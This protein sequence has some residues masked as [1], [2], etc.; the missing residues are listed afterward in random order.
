M[1]AVKTASLQASMNILLDGFDYG[2][3]S[4][5]FGVYSVDAN[6]DKQRKMIGGYD[7]GAAIVFE[8]R[9]FVANISTGKNQWLAE[10][11]A[12]PGVIL[13]RRMGSKMREYI[14]HNDNIQIDYLSVAEP[15]FESWMHENFES[16]AGKKAIRR[17]HEWRTARNAGDPSSDQ[18]AADSAAHPLASTTNLTAPQKPAQCSERRPQDRYMVMAGMARS[19]SRSRTRPPGVGFEFAPPTGGCDGRSH[20]WD[21][22]TKTLT[23]L[24]SADLPA[25]SWLART[26]AK[27]YTEYRGD[28]AMLE[29]LRSDFEAG[30]RKRRPIRDDELVDDRRGRRGFNRSSAVMLEFED[31]DFRAGRSPRRSASSVAAVAAILAEDRASSSGASSSQAEG[32][33]LFL[34]SSRESDKGLDI[35]SSSE[36]ASFSASSQSHVVKPP[37]AAAAARARGYGSTAKKAKTTTAETK[38]PGPRPPA[39][40]ANKTDK[41]CCHG[42]G[43]DMD[44]SHGTKKAGDWYKQK[45][46]GVTGY[47]CPACY[48]NWNFVRKK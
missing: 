30:R 44:I 32:S 3:W 18:I 41:W 12:L 15:L 2:E 19:R 31:A 17:A 24:F 16:E 28:Q 36:V 38:V 22:E 4:Y 33:R 6:V 47:Y 5:P 1:H 21:P 9:G 27:A 39:V 37:S 14:H 45:D 26:Q 13:L 46:N 42:P 23:G 25:N 34:E 7:S 48:R 29:N 8:S 35:W 11:G 20:G 43:C 10:K 40:Q